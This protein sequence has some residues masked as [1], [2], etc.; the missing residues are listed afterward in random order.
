[1]AQNAVASAWSTNPPNDEPSS[2]DGVG[3]ISQTPRQT[4][5]TASDPASDPFYNTHVPNGN[6][7]SQR[8]S[9]LGT[10]RFALSPSASPSE[11]KHAIE[12]HLA[13]T[14]KRIKDASDLG[15]NLV[16]QRQNLSQ[17]LKEVQRK[18][19]DREIGPELRQKLADFEAE[20]KDVVR[21]SARAFLGPK[22]Q[23]PQMDGFGSDDHVGDMFTL[24]M[25]KFI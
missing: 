5:R 9:H 16:R 23:L 17:Q 10:Q 7:Q 8:F 20:Y 21:E 1:M 12:A 13:E 19:A 24:G 6:Q 11:A 18:E 2:A 14:D 3:S 4:T 25:I 15:N 22:S